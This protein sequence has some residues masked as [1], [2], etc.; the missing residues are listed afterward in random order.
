[1]LNDNPGGNK[2]T[3]TEDCPIKWQESRQILWPIVLKL[4][5]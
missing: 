1:M 4:G 5:Q 3:L 2:L